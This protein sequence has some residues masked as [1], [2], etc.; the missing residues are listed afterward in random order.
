MVNAPVMWHRSMRFNAG[1][2]SELWGLPHNPLQTS[3]IFYST[4]THSQNSAHLIELSWSDYNHLTTSWIMK[5]N[6]NNTPEASLLQD[7]LYKVKTFQRHSSDSSI[8]VVFADVRKTQIIQNLL[9]TQTYFLMIFKL[10]IITISTLLKI[11]MLIQSTQSC[12]S[13]K[14][15]LIGNHSIKTL[16]FDK[17]NGQIRQVH[18]SLDGKTEGELK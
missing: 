4:T 8:T 17:W 1:V 16:Y 14:S 13:L 10:L 7:S 9:W 5:K 3:P 11:V 15:L 6:S 2:L 12:L 18:F